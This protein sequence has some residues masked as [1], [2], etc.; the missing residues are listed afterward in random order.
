MVTNQELMAI[1][2]RLAVAEREAQDYGLALAEA[3]METQRWV[4]K[5]NRLCEQV[6]IN[7]TKEV[8]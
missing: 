5:Y 7:L 1:A 3:Q 6:V 2:D 8:K 4:S